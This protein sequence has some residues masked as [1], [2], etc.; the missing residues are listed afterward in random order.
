MIIDGRAIAQDIA[1]RAKARAGRLEHPPLVVAIIGQ[2]T[3]AT[4]SY[5]KIKKERAIDAGCIFET[6]PL[7]SDFKEADSVIVQ[8]PLPDGI[9]QKDIC[10]SIPLGKDADVLST[11]ARAAFEQGTPDAV[12]P[13]V[14][15]AIREILT[16]TRINL[17]GKQVAVI[18]EGWLVGN[19]AALWFTQQGA[20]VTVVTKETKNLSSVLANA[21]IIVSGAG[22]PGLI[23]PSM[24]KDGVVLID[25]GTSESGGAIAGDVD[26]A[27]ASKCS[28]FTPVPGGVGPIAV[29]YLFQNAVTLAENID[30]KTF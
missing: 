15:G 28:V 30:R 25:A 11:A 1:A 6:R 5:L 22:Q 13:P 2:E 27:C 29:A 4:L 10:D 20:H 7:G 9:H 24:I 8:L 21:D 23:T 3:P 19:P 12:L 26:P 16:R 18:G 17:P 14:V